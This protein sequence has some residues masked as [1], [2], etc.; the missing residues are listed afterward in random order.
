MTA[1]V[2]NT[3]RTNF[4]AFAD[5]TRFPAG[6]VEYWLGLAAKLVNADRWGNLTDDGIKLFAAHN[7]VLE[8]Q[9]MDSAANGGTPGMSRGVINSESV[10]KVSVGYDTTAGIE[11]DA[12]HWNLTIYGTRFIRLARMMGMGGI[13]LG[14][15]VDIDT[16]LSSANAWAGPWSSTFPNRSQ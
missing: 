8:R 11:L 13:Q 9:A 3:F 4:P 10:D 2:E 16:A 1:P 5:A 12:G 14:A 7:L 6:M 15:G